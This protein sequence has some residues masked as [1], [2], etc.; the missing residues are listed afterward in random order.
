MKFLSIPVMSVAILAAA[1]FGA[2][3]QIKPEQEKGGSAPG[4]TAPSRS[5]GGQTEKESGQA[6]ERSERQ[7]QGDSGNRDAQGPRE[8]PS[9]EAPDAKD[10][11]DG[12]D[13]AGAG[14]DKPQ[15][16]AAEKH[17][18]GTRRDAQSE[19]PETD[20]R[21]ADQRP[22]GEGEKRAG[23]RDF[24]P[25]QRTVIRET[26]V[27]ERIRPAKLNI[28]VRVGAVIPRSVE[29]YAV[30]TTILDVYPTYRAYRLI[31]VDDNTLLIIDPRDWT[32]VDVI[33]V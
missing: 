24:R 6:G 7:G 1:S 9:A 28:Q 12:K 4:M 11:K 27:R 13:T 26:I 29:L 33:E 19:R 10:R 16:D 32:I 3:A 22:G 17:E 5:Q 18:D 23:G 31:M 25:E 8:R 14:Q 15:R 30:P 21:S 20:R 2:D